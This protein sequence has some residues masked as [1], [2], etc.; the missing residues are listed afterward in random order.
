MRLVV[1]PPE[2]IRWVDRDIV[3]VDKPADI[4]TVPFERGDRDTLVRLLGAVLT[5]RERSKRAPLYVVHRLDRN[6]S[7]LIAV[8]RTPVAFRELARA[9]ARR[10]EGYRAGVPWT[11]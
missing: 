10:I 9:I 11:E 5:R 3:V 8:A 7:G 4:L 6:T 1:V 2:A